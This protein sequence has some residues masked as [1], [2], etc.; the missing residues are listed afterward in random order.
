MPK[1][2]RIP[3]AQSPHWKAGPFAIR[4]PFVHYRFE[5]QDYTQG[6]VMCA[7]D[8]AAIPLTRW[9]TARIESTRPREP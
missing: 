3:E 5:W 8:L 6:L 2:D 7:V 1:K 4:L 9:R